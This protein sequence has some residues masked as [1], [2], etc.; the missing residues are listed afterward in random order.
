MCAKGALR[1]GEELREF[2]LHGVLLVED[3]LQ[4]DLRARLLLNHY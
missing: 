1:L 2:L 3:L 4:R